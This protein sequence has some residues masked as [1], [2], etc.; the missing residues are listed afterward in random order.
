MKNQSIIPIF[1]ATDDAYAPLLGVAL[2]SLLANTERGS[3]LRIHV[4]NSSLSEEN[5]ERLLSIAE[6]RTTLL[7]VD[8]KEK[9]APLAERLVLRDY[10][11]AA[12]YFR[13]FIS[14]LF[15]EYEK[16]L[17]LDCDIVLTGDIAKLYATPTDDV[18][19]AAI[20]EDV[21]ARM[22]VFGRYVECLFSIPRHEFFNAGILVMNLARF[23]S[24]CI[25]E[26]FLDL[27]S[28]RRFVVTQDED[29]L[30]VLCRGSVRFLPDTWNTSPFEEGDVTPLLVHY[31]M[32][33]KPWH[34]EDVRFSDIFWLY[35]DKTPYGPD[36]RAEL[37]AYD[38]AKVNRDRECHKNL[39][40]LAKSEMRK[41]RARKAKAVASTLKLTAVVAAVRRIAGLL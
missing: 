40:A 19:V 32:D 9:I 7:F 36:L 3:D 18:L 29:Y 33:R 23:R 6:G 14:E 28:R 4:L 37:A 30:N 16:A 10:Y 1:F 39:V 22:D 15:P 27:L 11:S 2:E 5:R 34:Y 21:M 13:L 8:M 20:P 25:M 24:E 38:E 31:K 26:R 35:A 41:E 12:T 17:Y